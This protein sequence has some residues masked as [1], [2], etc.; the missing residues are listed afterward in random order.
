M[1]TNVAYAGFSIKLNEDDQSEDRIKEIAKSL[2]HNWKDN[3]GWDDIMF[4]QSKFIG[5]WKPQIDID[6]IFGFIY[7]TYYEYDASDIK[8]KQPIS[9]IDGA[10]KEFID[11]THIMPKEEITTF[12]QIYYNGSDDPFKF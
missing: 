4:D 5:H 12:A 8:Y 10:L 9:A 1:S 11:Q 6:G 7:V 2:D 3:W